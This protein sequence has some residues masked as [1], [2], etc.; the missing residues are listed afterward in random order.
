[1]AFLYDEQEP[2]N[3]QA[4]NS[5]EWAEYLGKNVKAT[6]VEEAMYG[7]NDKT[8]SVLQAGY[9]TGKTQLAD[10]LKMNTF[11]LALHQKQHNDA[12]TY[13]RFAKRA[14]PYATVESSWDP[15]PR[16]T[17]EL[18]RLGNEAILE[19]KSAKSSFLKLRYAYQ[20][21]RLLRYAG[22]HDAARKV[23]AQFIQNNNSKSHVKGWALA[24]QA[25]TEPD[26]VKS[27]YLFSRVFEQYPERRIQA[28]RC[29]NWTHAPFGQ[30]LAI[31][32]NNHE[33]AVLYG[34]KGFGDPVYNTQYLKEI[35]SCEP[36]SPVI[37]I[38]LAREV[39][40]LEETFLDRKLSRQRTSIA[41]PVYSYN[42]W[43]YDSNYDSVRRSSVNHIIALN[44]FC[45]Q[46]FN[47]RK[48]PDYGLGKLV[49]AYLA[50][51]QNAT[52]AG[53][54]HLAA[55]KG[56]NLRD[57]LNDQKQLIN[58]LL[59]S[60]SI[61]QLNAVNEQSLLPSL[62]WLDKKVEA[63]A[64]VKV[65]IENMYSW[66]HYSQRPFA[67]SARNFYQ[68]ILAPAYYKQGAVSKAAVAL[69]KG[70]GTGNT[71]VYTAPV[72]LSFWQNSLHPSSVAKLI[73]WRN[74]PSKDAY[75][76]LLTQNL[77]KH[78]ADELYELLG[79]TYLRHHEYD[80]A[81]T[82]FKNVSKTKLDSLRSN[83]YDT[84]QGSDP[85]ISRLADYPKVWLT[86][87][88]RS[89]N[90]LEFAQTMNR[91]QQRM[92]TLPNAADYFKYATALYNTGM[93]GNSW[94]F[95]SY[96]W[97]ASDAGREKEN[98]YDDDYIQSTNAE[99][100]YLKA[101]ELSRDPEFKAKCTFM[102]AKC[103]QKQ[104]VMPS[105]AYYG[106]D[107]SDRYNKAENL[108]SRTI[109]QNTYFAQLKASYSKTRF[110]KTAINECSYFSDFLGMR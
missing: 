90:K 38:L 66:S 4:I 56:V 57:K 106:Y 42:Y 88:S 87:K 32:K 73:S 9:L 39:N 54:N 109:R 63:E 7:L 22:E 12:L 107:N 69:S 27:A 59:T 5:A 33:R 62:Q 96:S 11:L 29:Y 86:P 70:D 15:A 2:A 50:W 101:R 30:V 82:A 17:A 13:Y 3:E 89:Y 35:Y 23:Y 78:P 58:L 77:R 108:Y 105:Y 20:A 37:S 40:K 53:W 45:S 91:L 60:Q 83:F 48:S 1:M 31:A 10:S 34:I 55:L 25:G 47:D 18:S 67:T 79:T 28:Y 103:Q 93:H 14:E 41:S 75:L 6:H 102:A 46:L 51:M 85:F 74:N 36:Q 43:G 100:Y 8:D 24:Q 81:A 19:A 97:A 99:K 16:D 94:C 80:K 21:Q 110:Y 65:S 92:K 26:S 52:K 104:M 98:Y 72:T 44:N 64:K 61:R 49:P 95:I 68:T 76:K 71:D 84:G